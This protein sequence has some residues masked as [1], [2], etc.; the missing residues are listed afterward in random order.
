M[1]EKYWPETVVLWGAGATKYLGIYTTKELSELILKITLGDFSFL[2]GKNKKIS[3]SF[4]K[5][6]TIDLL[7]DKNIS[8]V[9]DFK[10]LSTIIRI[11]PKFNINELFTMLDQLIENN[12]GFNA[13][14]NNKKEFIRVE[15]IKGAKRCLIL[16][17]EELE[18]I[19]IQNKPGCFDENKIK[20]YYELSDILSQLMV[21]EAREFDK[22][23]YKRDTRKFY[24]YS[25]AL[26][27]FNWDPVFSWNIYNAHRKQ[28]QKH[29][30]L[31]D[32]FTLNLST[33]FGIQIASR[34]DRD[35]EIYYTANESHC[36]EVN[37][38]R[39][40]S[41]V[42]RIGKVLFPH[43]MFG[44]RICPE[45]GKSIADFSQNGNLFSTQC[46][47]P[48][49]LNEL[50]I[51]WKYSTDKEKKYRNGAI[52]CPY[53]GQITYPYDMPLIMQTSLRNESIFPLYNIKTELGLLLKNAKHIVF[54]G[55]SLPTDD[56]IVKTFFMS[57]VAGSD[58]NK[59]KCTIIN[60][61]EKY[62][63]SDKWISGEKIVDYLKENK[64]TSTSRCIRSIC[65]I[66]NIKNT[67][68][69]LKGIP[70]VFIKNGKLSRE[71]VLDVLY[72]KEYF[73]EGFPIN[74]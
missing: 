40:S 63:N 39:Y 66:F 57:S 11:N 21:E 55:Y 18:R 70:G 16:L 69:S 14:F 26:V 33:D 43:G 30:K 10:A 27:S 1:P 59:L 42:L 9:Y 37:N 34:N 15:R 68:V 47:G 38:S 35:S 3:D 58:R 54:A 29:I 52:E 45:C 13:F 32:N 44:C 7:E 56:I 46:F 36:R 64:G 61:D 71:S 20:P 65:D 19:S 6:V 28:N 51:G 50:Q 24:M 22:R 17:I 53:C 4:K 41:K 73:K 74:R 31:R 23:G 49:I 72:P 62:L 5:L 25:Y 8:E 12:R 67:R 2:N 48:S 60:H